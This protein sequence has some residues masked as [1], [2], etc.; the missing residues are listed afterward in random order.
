MTTR[1]PL[2]CCCGGL[3]AQYQ[4]AGVSFA[5]MV[6][7]AMRVAMRVTMRAMMVMQI[8][9]ITLAGQLDGRG[10]GEMVAAPHEGARDDFCVDSWRCL[11]A[12]VTEWLL[13]TPVM[14]R[15]R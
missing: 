12:S 10:E 5:S 14:C 6:R 11:G 7:V 2:G 8:K 1:W 9:T 3:E 15:P 13:R 4:L